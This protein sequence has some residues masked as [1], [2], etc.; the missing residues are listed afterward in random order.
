MKK[1]NYSDWIATIDTAWGD[2][3]QIYHR[4]QELEI[5]CNCSTGKPLTVSVETPTAAIQVWNVARQP[6]LDRC[7]LVDW[8]DRCLILQAA[9]HGSELLYD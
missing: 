2:R 6:S 8:L 3:W 4:L 5:S 7:Q 1:V 9:R